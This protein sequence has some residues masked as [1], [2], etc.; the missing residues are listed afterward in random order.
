M[1]KHTTFTTINSMLSKKHNVRLRLDDKTIALIC[2]CESEQIYQVMLSLY[3][4]KNTSD[5]FVKESIV[6]VSRETRKPIG[7]DMQKE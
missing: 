6:R 7:F 1:D 4:A 3:E 2:K 5:D